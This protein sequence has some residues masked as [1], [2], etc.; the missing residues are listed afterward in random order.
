M[1]RNTF[2]AVLFCSLILLFIGGCGELEKGDFPTNVPP[3]LYLV[4]VP[5]EDAAFSTNPRVYWWGTDSDGR[6]MEYQYIVIPEA[7]LDGEGNIEDLGLIP[8]DKDGFVDSLFVKTIESIS[9]TKWADSLIARELSESGF[10]AHRDS[11]TAVIDTQTAVDMMMFAE[12]DTTIFVN[13]YFFVRAVD[14]SGA[15]SKI[16]KPNTKGGHV[17]RRLARNNHPPNTH[18]DTVNFAKEGIYYCLP[19]TTETWK[20]IKLQ[21]EGSDSSDYP[22][23]Q[24]DFYYKWEIFGPF[25]NPSVVELGAPVDSSWNDV[26]GSRWVLQTSHTFTNLKNYDEEGGG[27]HGWYLF[28][29]SSRDDAFVVDETPDS[30]FIHIVHPL[31]SFYP[32]S[33][34][35]VL[36]VDATIYGSPKKYG[37]PAEEE[38]RIQVLSIYDKLMSNIET[39]LGIDYVIWYDTASGPKSTHN[40]PNEL[41]LPNYKLVIVLNHCRDPGIGRVGMDIDSGYVQYKNYLDVGGNVWFLGMNDWSLIGEGWHNTDSGDRNSE[42]GSRFVTADLARFY[43]GLHKVYF[44]H[45]L[46][47]NRNDEFIGAKPFLGASIDLPYLESDSLKVETLLRWRFG[48][49]DPRE[50]NGNAIPQ[51]GPVVISPWTERL[52]DFVSIYGMNSQ[53]AGKPCAVRFSGSTFKTSEFFFPLYLVKEDGAEEVMKSMIQWF[54]E[55]TVP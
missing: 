18:I 10:H 42:F 1:N 19:E 50:P 38:G 32:E 21:W 12:L 29:V 23:K 2:L 6:I 3:Q 13:Q 17:F 34:R 37:F 8:K 46:T 26:V 7:K 14:N 55:P 45:W 43:F 11:L 24:P 41:L 52:Y 22:R 48:G 35:K 39:E 44:P 53:L 16:W 9:H 28:R 20:G 27:S 31:I 47:G 54:L 4:N 33:Q 40:P 30:I 5:Q 15:V 49:D 25:E 36:V 51:V